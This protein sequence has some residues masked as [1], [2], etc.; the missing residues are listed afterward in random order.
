MKIVFAFLMWVTFAAAAFA[1]EESIGRFQLF[2]GTLG[3]ESK[4]GTSSPI[5]V[6]LRIDTKT[7]KTWQYLSVQEKSGKYIEYWSE[8]AEHLPKE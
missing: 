8:I 1:E 7:G 6:I 3:V 2:G 4:S 5:P